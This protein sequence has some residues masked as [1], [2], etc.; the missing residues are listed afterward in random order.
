MT[1]HDAFKHVMAGGTLT[2]EEAYTAMRELMGGTAPPELISGFIVV[3]RYKTE[4]VPEITGFAR[5]MREWSIKIRPN[6]KGRLV[7]TCGTG[8]AP[9]K[10]FN[11]STASA[12]V[13]AAAGVPIAK[14][15]NKSVTRPSGSADVL[16]A[17]GTNLQVPPPRVEKII[18]EV[19]IGFLLAPAFHPSMK[20]A[21]PTRNALQIRTVFNLLGPLTNPAGAKG[22]VVGVHDPAYVE[23]LANV[24]LRLGTEHALVVHGAGMDE[25]TLAGPT[26]TAEVRDGK[27]SRRD[28]S[29]K[30]LGF[31][32]RRPDEYAALSPTE[33]AKAIRTILS[34]GARG[35]RREIIEYNAGLAIYVGGKANDM[36]EGM[37]RANE[38]L[39]TDAGANKLDQFITATRA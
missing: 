18:E 35:A 16:A 20:N 2:E 28:F 29:P 12:F 17:L 26:R 38:I 30:D 25:A 21:A 1:L 23:P 10:C 9:V 19:G 15:G 6:V 4:T 13:A 24:L 3:M 5:A 11:I 22:Q 31:A 32:I 37:A 33:S 36:Q 39:E 14:H 27:V 7:D 8:G 34:G